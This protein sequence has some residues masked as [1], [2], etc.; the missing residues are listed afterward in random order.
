MQTEASHGWAAVGKSEHEE[1]DRDQLA[2][3]TAG[4]AAVG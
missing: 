2:P 4:G 1:A 3:R